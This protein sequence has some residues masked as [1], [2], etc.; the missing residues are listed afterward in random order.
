MAGRTRNTAVEVGSTI[1]E[2]QVPRSKR[3][4]SS[5]STDNETLQVECN[6]CKAERLSKARVAANNFAL[7]LLV[8]YLTS[9]CANIAVALLNL[10]DW[11]RG[12][13][14]FAATLALDSR[15]ALHDLHSTCKF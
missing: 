8:S 1:H 3:N 7:V 4:S 6:A 11:K 9:L 5:A 10:S 13:L 12:S 15:S 14:A 2:L